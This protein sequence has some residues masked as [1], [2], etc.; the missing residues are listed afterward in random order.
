MGDGRSGF[1]YSISNQAYGWIISNHIAVG[2]GV[3][4][5]LYTWARGA[6]DPDDS[7]SGGLVRAQ[8]YDSGGASIGYQDAV[9]IAP[10]SLTTTWQRAGGR[11]TAPAGAVTARIVLYLYQASGWIAY[12]DVEMVRVGQTTNLVADP[13]FDLGTGWTSGPASFA[14][15]TSFWRGGW[16]M[17]AGRSGLGYSISNQ[18]YGCLYSDPVTVLPEA[19][20]DLRTWVR[21]EIDPDGSLSGWILRAHSYDAD[22]ND[23]GHSDLAAG[24]TLT[25]TWTKQGGIFTTPAGT[26]TL[27]VFLYLHQ[28]SGWANFDDVALSLEPLSVSDPDPITVDIAPGEST[29][30]TVTVSGGARPHNKRWQYSADNTSYSDLGN[31]DGYSGTG[32]TALTISNATTA[33][34]G[35]YRCK[36]WDADPTSPTIHSAPA[37]VTVSNPI[38]VTGPTPSSIVI[39]EGMSMSLAITTTGGVGTLHPRWQ[40]LDGGSWRNLQEGELGWSGALSTTLS[41]TSGQVAASGT[42]RCRV[43]DDSD[44]Q[45]TVYSSNA[46]VTVNPAPAIYSGPTPAVATIDYGTNASFTVYLEG[47]TH[48][49]NVT[50]QRSLDGSSWENVVNDSH[51]SGAGSYYSVSGQPY[52]G[53]TR[54]DIFDANINQDRYYRVR[55]RDAS[56]PASAEVY[57]GSARLYVHQVP[58]YGTPFALDTTN[59]TIQAEDFDR[60]G[61][62]LAYHDT[63]A[64][65]LGGAYRST[66]VDIGPDLVGGHY[67]GWFE[68]GE[69]L[70]Y[71]VDVANTNSD[72]WDIT[73][74]YGTAN[75]SNYARLRLDGTDVTGLINLP[76]TGGWGIAALHTIEDVYLA[77]GNGKEIRLDLGTG[78]WSCDWIR[79][80]KI[81][82][83]DD[84]AGHGN[85]ALLDNTATDVGPNI[86]QKLT[87][88]ATSSMIFTNNHITNSTGSGSHVATVDYDPLSSD[89]DVST[90]EADI[91]ADSAGWVGLGFSSSATGILTSYGQVWVNLRTLLDGGGNPYGRAVVKANGTAIELGRKDSSGGNYPY[92]ANGYNNVRVEYNRVTHQVTVWINQVKIISGVDLDSWGFVPVISQ[93]GFQLYQPPST[94]DVTKV[95]NFD[96]TISTTATQ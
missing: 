95:D 80:A 83:Q 72:K 41:S 25:T 57:S 22:G 77:P 48:P 67:V 7:L 94:S 65:N 84:F 50:W 75:P 34:S 18:A 13:G 82:G 93:A 88:H 59:R 39:T 89:R 51:Y 53:Y 32:S 68:D 86:G 55:F 52:D 31:T 87:W 35:W 49:R 27:R 26:T 14:P 44:P 11:V 64:D 62:G 23:L 92:D 91:D 3:Q 79:F 43:R 15:G 4:Y 21:G 63:T 81:M 73:I 70:E 33:H 24:S 29:T 74:R 42:Y 28:A 20:Y 90:V 66:R 46:I 37:R 45:Q 1:G 6:I 78:G 40:L 38:V 61:E 85:G 69:W 12:D 58:Y 96:L 56:Y 19:D 16:G 8:F 5:D 30:L 71:S 47:G 17:A 60:G 54:L 9:S 10:G 2:A 36:V 76:S